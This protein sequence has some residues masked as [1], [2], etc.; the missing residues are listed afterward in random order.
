MDTCVLAPTS[1][2]QSVSGPLNL[3]RGARHASIAVGKE[4]AL[5]IG[6][7]GGSPYTITVH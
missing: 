1:G 3:P 5:E 2:K 7:A 6:V 4:Y